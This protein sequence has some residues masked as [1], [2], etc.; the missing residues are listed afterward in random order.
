MCV[1]SFRVTYILP[2]SVHEIPKRKRKRKR[3]RQR[4]RKRVDQTRK[5]KR[6]QRTNKNSRVVINIYEYYALSFRRG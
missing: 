3:K 1:F 6:E 2:L 4:Q 5:K